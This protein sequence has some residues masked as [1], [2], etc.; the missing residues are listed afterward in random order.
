MILQLE[1]STPGSTCYERQYTYSYFYSYSSYYYY[2]YTYYDYCSF[3][4]C[5]YTTNR[6]CCSSY[7]SDGTNNKADYT[8]L[9]VGCT[10]G[11]IF[12]VSIV[13]TIIACVCKCVN[14]SSPHRGIVV[15][16][17]PQAARVG[18]NMQ[19]VGPNGQYIPPPVY[20]PPPMD[21]AGNL[22]MA[23]V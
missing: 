5:G 17:A 11:S 23:H 7:D 4:C 15:A 3:G 1:E 6:Y 22:N 9:I 13:V 16:P 18:I 12:F 10:L 8:G 14:K 21:Q 20:Q 2:Y 19:Q